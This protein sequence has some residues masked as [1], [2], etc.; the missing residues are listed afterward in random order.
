MSIVHSILLIVVHVLI[1]CTGS[2]FFSVMFS[3]VFFKSKQLNESC[4]MVS[5]ER[6]VFELLVS[7][8]HQKNP[9]LIE[10]NIKAIFYQ[11]RLLKN[12][13]NLKLLQVRWYFHKS[14]NRSKIQN[15]ILRKHFVLHPCLLNIQQARFNTSLNIY[16]CQYPCSV[17]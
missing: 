8:K 16:L 1:M 17:G 15:T 13:P 3:R 12:C 4:K 11:A 2:I 9:K 6:V 14:K 5:I 7:W 10:I